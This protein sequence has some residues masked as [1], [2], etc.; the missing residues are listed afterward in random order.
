MWQCV[1][2]IIASGTGNDRSE[3]QKTSWVGRDLGDWGQQT[4][5]S[6]FHFTFSHS[7]TISRFLCLRMKKAGLRTHR[8]I[9]GGKRQWNAKNVCCL[10]CCHDAH[11]CS[12]PAWLRLKGKKK[13]LYGALFWFWF[14]II[15]II[16]I[17]TLNFF[18]DCDAQGQ[19]VSPVAMRSSRTRWTG[20]L[21]TISIGLHCNPVLRTE[22]LQIDLRT[23]LKGYNIVWI[24]HLTYK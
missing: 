7:D 19:Y 4:W 2:A 23:R 3:R 8:P 1:D 22:K 18:P 20:S 13:I 10:Q 11:A 17:F 9:F 16:L 24:N 5:F 14:S 6:S 15:V 12:R 21:I